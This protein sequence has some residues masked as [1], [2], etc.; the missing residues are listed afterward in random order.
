MA[1]LL[2]T[3]DPSEEVP[4]ET[5]PDFEYGQT[6]SEDEMESSADL[7]ASDTEEA[8]GMTDTAAH[9][10]VAAAKVASNF[11]TFAWAFV[12]FGVAILALSFLFELL[13]PFSLTPEE[14]TARAVD[15][16]T[17]VQ[18]VY[19]FSTTAV[20]MGTTLVRPVVPVFNSVV[21]YVATPLVF[22]FME[23]VAS[24]LPPNFDP[25]LFYGMS[26]KDPVTGKRQDV[27]YYG[28]SCSA[29][30]SASEQLNAISSKPTDA[31]YGAR[32]AMAWCGLKG[33]YQA[34]ITGMHTGR[35][36]AQDHRSE[37]GWMASNHTEV[38]RERVGDHFLIPWEIVERVMERRLSHANARQLREL[39]QVRQLLHDSSDSDMPEGMS[40]DLL[41]DIVRTL[42]MSVQDVADLMSTIA[43][44]VIYLLGSVADLVLH[45]LYVLLDELAPIVANLFMTM[46]TVVA[47]LI[48]SL[49]QY[50]PFSQILDFVLDIIVIFL[51]RYVVP[52][53]FFL[54]NSLM[55][56]F[57]VMDYESWD[58]ELACIDQHCTFGDGPRDW[59]LFTSFWLVV[60]QI[61]TVIVETFESGARLFGADES[62]LDFLSGL[63]TNLQYTIG[64]A[65]GNGTMRCEQCFVCKVPEWRMLTYFFTSLV[66]CVDPH[67][68]QTYAFNVQDQ[69]KPNGSFYYAVC[70]SRLDLTKAE[71]WRQGAYRPEFL[72]EWATKFSKL[73]KSWGGTSNAAGY[74][75]NQLAHSWL[76]RVALDQYETPE[77]AA[78]A[79]YKLACMYSDEGLI[80]T[81]F[82]ENLD[83]SL[84]Y[85][86]GSDYYAY[87]HDP[88]TYQAS[89]FLYDACRQTSFGTYYVPA[90]RDVI[91][92]GNEASSCFFDVPACL[93]Q[94]D[95]C[96]G[97]CATSGPNQDFFTEIAKTQLAPETHTYVADCNSRVVELTLPLFGQYGQN[98]Q[99]FAADIGAR[100]GLT[101]VDPSSV[102]G[103][104]AQ[105]VR[106][107]VTGENGLAYTPSRGIVLAYTIPPPSPPP[108]PPPPPAP[109]RLSPP[110]A[111]SPPPPPPYT[112]PSPMPHPPPPPPQSPP[113]WCGSVGGV[114]G[115]PLPQISGLESEP[116]VQSGTSA[117]S[118]EPMSGRQVCIFA[119]RVLDARVRADFCFLESEAE[120]QDA[121]RDDG[122]R[123]YPLTAGAPPMPPTLDAAIAAALMGS[124][125]PPPPPTP[126]FRA[127]L[128][129]ANGRRLQAQDDYDPV[130]RY[131]RA[132]WPTFRESVLAVTPHLTTSVICG[133]LCVAN[134]SCVAFVSRPN[135]DVTVESECIL[136]KSRG[137]C[138]L[139]QFAS[140]LGTTAAQKREYRCDSFANRRCIEL[141]AILPGDIRR[142]QVQAPTEDATLTFDMARQACEDRS[143]SFQTYMPTLPSPRNSVEAYASLVFARKQ[144][145]SAFWVERV[146]DQA[147][148]SYR[149]SPHWPWTVPGGLCAGKKS[150]DACDDGSRNGCALIYSPYSSLYMAATIVPCATARATGLVCFANQADVPSPPAPPPIYGFEPPKPSP[151]PFHENTPPP[152]MPIRARSARARFSHLMV[153]RHTAKVCDKTNGEFGLQQHC[154]DLVR[155]LLPFA[156]VGDMAE[157]PLCGAIKPYESFTATASELNVILTRLG[158]E[159]RKPPGGSLCW[160]DCKTFQNY[161][162]AQS[163]TSGCL[164]FIS[165]ACS[166][167]AYRRAL[168]AC[169]D[170]LPSDPPPPSSPPP[171]PLYRSQLDHVGFKFARSGRCMAKP[172]SSKILTSSLSATAGLAQ[173]LE[174][175]P[176][177]LAMNKK[178]NQTLDLT[179]VS[180]ASQIRAQATNELNALLY[181][182][183]STT[184]GPDLTVSPNEIFPEHTLELSQWLPVGLHGG[185]GGVNTLR[186]PEALVA[187]CAEECARRETQAP[188]RCMSFAARSRML[189]HGDWSLSKLASL[190][191]HNSYPAIAPHLPECELY[192]I[193]GTYETCAESE[194]DKLDPP[195]P[196]CVDAWNRG[197]GYESGC[198]EVPRTA[199]QMRTRLS[200][201][202]E[203]FVMSER[204]PSPPPPPLGLVVTGTTTCPMLPTLEA[205]RALAWAQFR[206]EITLLPQR[207]NGAG[208]TLGCFSG[209]NFD[210]S[211]G[212]FNPVMPIDELEDSDFSTGYA[213]GQYN[214]F[215]CR[216][217]HFKFC[218]CAYPENALAIPPPPPPPPLYEEGA[219]LTASPP[220][221]LGEEPSIYYRMI[222]SGRAFGC[223]RGGVE[224][225]ASPMTANSSYTSTPLFTRC[226][227]DSTHAQVELLLVQSSVLSESWSAGPLGSQP[228]ACGLACARMPNVYMRLRGFEISPTFVNGVLDPARLECRCVVPYGTVRVEDAQQTEQYNAEQDVADIPKWRRDSH[229]V[230]HDVSE[231]TLLRLASQPR[232]G[233][234]VF[235]AQAYLRRAESQKPKEIEEL[236]AGVGD[237]TPLQ[238]RQHISLQATTRIT[239][240][241]TLQDVPYAST[242]ARATWNVP[243]SA[244]QLGDDILRIAANEQYRD[245]LDV[246]GGLSYLLDH[247]KDE[248]G[249]SLLDELVHG[250]NLTGLQNTSVL[251]QEWT[252]RWG[253]PSPPPSGYETSSG[254]F[255]PGEGS[256]GD[257]D[258]SDYSTDTSANQALRSAWRALLLNTF[259]HG[260]RG[261]TAEA[262]SRSGAQ[263]VLYFLSSDG[264]GCSAWCSTQSGASLQSAATH[265]VNWDSSKNTWSNPS[266][267]SPVLAVTGRASNEMT[268][269][270]TQRCAC[271]GSP[272]GGFQVPSDMEVAEWIES[273]PSLRA[274]HGEPQNVLLY[275]AVI[276]AIDV[277]T[278]V[279]LCFGGRAM[280]NSLPPPPGSPPSPFPPPPGTP[281]YE[282]HTRRSH[283]EYDASLI[284]SWAT[285]DVAPLGVTWVKSPTDLYPASSRE[286]ASER[287]KMG[288]WCLADIEQKYGPS[289]LRSSRDGSIPTLLTGNTREFYVDSNDRGDAQCQR[290][291]EDDITCGAAQFWGRPYAHSSLVY[292]APPPA[293]PKLELKWQ[294]RCLYAEP[295]LNKCCEPTEFFADPCLCGSH[296]H[297]RPALMCDN[298]EVILYNAPVAASPPPSF[299]TSSTAS[300]NT[301]YKRD[302]GEF[303]FEPK[304]YKTLPEARASLSAL[305]VEVDIHGQAATQDPQAIEYRCPWDCP[306]TMQ[307]LDMHTWWKL[308][309]CQSLYQYDTEPTPAQLSGCKY[310]TLGPKL[311]PINPFLYAT[312]SPYDSSYT[313]GMARSTNPPPPPVPVNTN[314]A[315]PGDRSNDA[316]LIEIAKDRVRSVQTEVELPHF[317]FM[318][319]AEDAYTAED[320]C[321]ACMQEERCGLVSYLRGRTHPSQ[322]QCRRWAVIL[323]TPYD[324]GPYGQWLKK[325]V[326]SMKGDS[327]LPSLRSTYAMPILGEASLHCRNAGTGSDSE[328]TTWR[329][330]LTTD[331]C[332]A[333]RLIVPPAP[334]PTPHTPPW[335]PAPP[336]SPVEPPQG[337]TKWTIHPYNGLLS[338]GRDADGNLTTSEM[339]AITCGGKDQPV[340]LF[341]PQGNTSAKD[342]AYYK[343]SGLLGTIDYRVTPVLSSSQAACP[344]ECQSFEEMKDP[345]EESDEPSRVVEM[346]Y[347]GNGSTSYEFQPRNARFVGTQ[348]ERSPAENGDARCCMG[349]CQAGSVCQ[350][351][352]EPWGGQVYSLDL[353]APQWVTAV[354]LERGLRLLSSVEPG[355]AEDGTFKGHP[356]GDA[357]DNLGYTIYVSMGDC[358][359]SSTYNPMNLSMYGYDDTLHD[360]KHWQQDA[361]CTFPEG[362]SE[363]IF[364]SLSQQAARQ[365]R[366]RAHNDEYA[367]PI[368]VPGSQNTIWHRAEKNGN[369]ASNALRATPRYGRY[370]VIQVNP[371]TIATALKE[372]T[373]SKHLCQP[374]A[375]ETTNAAQGLV[376]QTGGRGDHQP[377]YG[378]EH[379]NISDY[380]DVITPAEPSAYLKNGFPLRLQRT[381]IFGPPGRS[382]SGVSLHGLNDVQ[383]QSSCDQQCKSDPD[384]H[385]TWFGHVRHEPPEGILSSD[386]YFCYLIDL[387]ICHVDDDSDCQ[388]NDEM[389]W[390][391]YKNDIVTTRELYDRTLPTTSLVKAT[392]R[393]DICG[394]MRVLQADE[395]TCRC[396]RLRPMS[397]TGFDEGGEFRPY[398]ILNESAF[399]ATV[400]TPSGDVRVPN[401]D[402]DRSDAYAF[403][404]DSSTLYEEC[405]DGWR[406]DEQIEKYQISLDDASERATYWLQNVTFDLYDNTEDFKHFCSHHVIENKLKWSYESP[407]EALQVLIRSIHFGE[408]TYEVCTTAKM[409]SMNNIY[410]YIF[411]AFVSQAQRRCGY[412]TRVANC[413]GDDWGRS[414]LG[415]M[416]AWADTNR[417]REGT[418]LYKPGPV[419]KVHVKS[420]PL[421]C[422][423]PTSPKPPPPPPP[424]FPPP[425]SPSPAPPNPNRPPRPPP[426]SPFP[427]PPPPDPSP[428]PPPPRIIFERRISFLKQKTESEINPDWCGDQNLIS[429]CQGSLSDFLFVTNDEVDAECK[430]Q[431]DNSWSYRPYAN[432]LGQCAGISCC[433]VW[434]ATCESLTPYIESPP[435]PPPPARYDFSSFR[436][437]GRRLTVQTATGA[438]S[439][440]QGIVGLTQRS[441]VCKIWEREPPPPQPPHPPEPPAPP[442]RLSTRRAA[443][444]RGR[445]FSAKA[446]RLLKTMPSHPR[447]KL[448]PGTRQQP[449]KYDGKNVIHSASQMWK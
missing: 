77:E 368:N 426:P 281:D 176:F 104:V 301:D 327:P 181:G 65:G 120:V 117:D 203:Y 125:N 159:S 198:G 82:D 399:Y 373:S 216:W 219:F 227:V 193:D 56:A 200:G 258:T 416:P 152:P 280:I 78:E 423:D 390:I 237:A 97:S 141:P 50:E 444:S 142:R 59:I 94:R 222:A 4:P 262:I 116:S 88:M 132:S 48:M 293:P 287:A 354:A 307:P 402:W 8:S 442:S 85:H 187:L 362:P 276:W 92:W 410:N 24:L 319:D 355:T 329:K 274:K 241:P 108:T 163:A 34:G 84:P 233:A 33:W 37:D 5:S 204:P 18:R 432:S 52:L 306:V 408:N 420:I 23:Q 101:A 10:V 67:N 175:D 191:Q 9:T 27:P 345:A 83:A 15:T 201:S 260:S 95:V 228:Q 375:W 370:V 189:H 332:F 29:G 414:D 341:S 140:E 41:D 45:V 19:D 422:S 309:P 261:E 54:V 167:E 317:T 221:M 218:G 158:G 419:R 99:Q 273:W 366:H 411:K 271:Y 55:C 361:K 431:L 69:C 185:V 247:W 190:F 435:P 448:V 110:P 243:S 264:M 42:S 407:I 21:Q 379:F 210:R 325:A 36:L 353:G 445:A 215:D 401:V 395:S 182:T 35:R 328:W 377:F 231:L 318:A 449:T 284:S 367:T 128:R 245:A 76:D 429:C 249:T 246:T 252:D 320:C 372:P 303:A 80:R 224:T 404:V 63:E 70:N 394:T 285:G 363:S 278:P 425:P 40:A 137:A 156:R 138:V 323:E 257:Y 12:V 393:E 226:R 316:D 178:Y 266:D 302:P 359:R 180:L 331:N 244:S 406:V 135:F 144:G 299:A 214:T 22:I 46:I 384:C 161:P 417:V 291:C 194:S 170:P 259:K 153:R 139:R 248:Y 14:A 150:E 300:Y 53:I 412:A 168:Q 232:Q 154:S 79:M 60:D 253:W 165:S 250:V 391:G 98:Q 100:T 148:Q 143:A 30:L 202:Y 220:E 289:G 38:L 312:L 169:V 256:S 151:P 58:K 356:F 441:G 304:E 294:A 439:L 72:T 206:V 114:E 86:I 263:A 349:V 403:N 427:D 107:W 115:I 277:S 288:L 382:V 195:P 424:P 398:T 440:E 186:S 342:L 242:L 389:F 324:M 164:N 333:E 160:P 225:V 310:S 2:P 109:L 188:G 360:A 305:G 130:A 157:S 340:Y 334:P 296:S 123:V 75:A 1:S 286:E 336:P 13:Y 234:W 343:L 346:I 192:T 290:A 134:S 386:N 124:P 20:N 365:L 337:I 357:I 383:R 434:E 397:L 213:P 371:C 43:G 347:G 272:D 344:W 93:K 81:A 254:D 145:V 239:S 118:S 388:W 421:T 196:R 322:S 236:E 47:E 223:G 147:T 199:F 230:P 283:G 183:P 339:W 172:D 314:D 121:R 105:I 74:R 269:M 122:S 174:K 133:Q 409:D 31:N 184:R 326:P 155:A 119:R 385:A 166:E 177:Y 103:E 438:L 229:R 68:L 358:Q 127:D 330:T 350:T 321:K 428:P 26:P 238:V 162:D 17:V 106:Q 352:G 131:S 265:E 28:Y 211:R 7:A 268:D 447:P 270:T 381:R 73:S 279:P 212:T 113:P 209:C 292:E 136:L 437:Q 308:D 197:I 369:K 71:P 380:Y 129:S 25:D 126:Q 89:Y 387:P 64:G 49:V 295:P 149:A 205:C 3:V 255:T 376:S 396:K 298:E 57:H 392:A 378:S 418:T 91:E 311:K 235:S 173:A 112:T 267:P 217:G 32:T 315:F 16:L 39:Q 433:L 240:F 335:P 179:E 275:D 207:C 430:S 405:I 44:F 87:G 6:D 282:L 62:G 436:G 351:S 208:P 297:H 338:E 66:G 446:T 96:L 313:H 111:R 364:A 51:M 90:F 374:L 102:D 348:T 415:D 11:F 413:N 400:N 171:A 251:L 443:A 61:T 146:F